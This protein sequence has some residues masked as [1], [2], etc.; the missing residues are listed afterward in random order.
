MSQ[1]PLKILIPSADCEIEAIS[2]PG[3]PHLVGL[4]FDNHAAALADV[5]GW[6]ESDRA[7]LSQAPGVNPRAILMGAEKL[8][9]D[10]RRQFEIMFGNYL[11]IVAGKA[12]S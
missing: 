6:V 1:F 12:H 5:S 2:V 11:S 10:L 9:H 8:R 7:W 4:Q 3:R